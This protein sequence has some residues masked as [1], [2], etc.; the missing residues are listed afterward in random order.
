[1]LFSSGSSV[2]AYPLK[3]TFLETKTELQFPVQAM[4]VVPKRNFKK[5]H[6]RNRI[7][8]RMREYY[9]LNK[10]NLY[11]QLNQKGQKY[12]LAFIFT[13]KKEEEYPAIGAAFDKLFEK[14]LKQ[15]PA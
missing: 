15:N 5:A 3:L 8:R 4:F 7:K 6:D 1:V 13:G 10:K 14:M 2:N 12:I 11:E 9:R